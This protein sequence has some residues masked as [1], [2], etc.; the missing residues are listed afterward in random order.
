MPELTD[1]QRAEA[2]AK[3]YHIPPRK[4]PADDSGYFEK[5]TQA[6]FQAGFSWE[7]IRNKW[8]N[9]RAAFDN[10]DVE[11]VARYGP[12]EVERLLGDE[13]IVRNG[14]KIEATIQNAQTMRR[15]IDEHGSF[16]TYLRTLDNLTYDQRVK[17][18][19]KKFKWLGRTGAFF[20]LYTVAEEVP[21]WKDR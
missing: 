16:H 11:K 17:M 9:F 18:L 6:V 10:F 14:R 5:I 15:L 12:Y 4:R 2:E 7:V 8:D 20:F 21:E 1:E 13:G 3:G 19:T